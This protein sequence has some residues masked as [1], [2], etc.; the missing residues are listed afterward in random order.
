MALSKV[1]LIAI[2][3][4]GDGPTGPTT[5]TVPSRDA[6]LSA[7]CQALAANVHIFTRVLSLLAKCYPRHYPVLQ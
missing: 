2:N 4:I 5:V 1:G 6:S 3:V 7:V